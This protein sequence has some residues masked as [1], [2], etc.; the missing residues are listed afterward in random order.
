MQEVLKGD[1]PAASFRPPAPGLASAAWGGGGLEGHGEEWA[2]SL[3][4]QATALA[5]AF[6]SEEMFYL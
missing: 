1:A 6:V 4:P 3:W 2:M 5:N